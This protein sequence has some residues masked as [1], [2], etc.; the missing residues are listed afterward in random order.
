MTL[1]SDL[2]DFDETADL[3]LLMLEGESEIPSLSIYCYFDVE[4]IF[5]MWSLWTDL[6]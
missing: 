1:L 5:V 2:S 3:A 4:Y 6:R